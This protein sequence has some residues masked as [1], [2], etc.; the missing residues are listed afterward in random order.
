MRKV[1]LMS[2]PGIRHAPLP[3]AATL[4][5][6]VAAGGDSGLVDVHQH[7]IPPSWRALAE[8]GTGN[9]GWRLPAWDPEAAHLFRQARGIEAAVLSNNISSVLVGRTDQARMVRESNDY[10]ASLVAETP[11]E[12]GFFA[13]LPLPD[14]DGALTEVARSLDDLGAEGVVLPTS[15]A[16]AYLSEP[17]FEPLWAELDHR[18]A[19][20]FLHPDEPTFPPVSGV[21]AVLV[22]FV[23]ETMRCAVGLVAHGVVHRHPGVQIILS[24]GGGGLASIAHR[25]SYGLPMIHPERSE[26]EWLADFRSFYVETAL[27]STDPALSA[28]TAFLP[29]GHVLFGTDHPY[30][31]DPVVDRF[32]SLLDESILSDE[33]RA[34]VESGAA[35]ALFP[36]FAAHTARPS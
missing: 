24:H 1:T 35:Q 30:A 15:V 36:R 26:E 12:L 29:E 4:V 31:P 2:A 3:S 11:Q 33:H 9:V 25:V 16:G 23:V 20:I 28:L 19:V 5:T 18:Q 32:R 7:V 10:C 21:P 22:D 27:A 34:S 14:L 13:S 8:Q 17:A 6:D